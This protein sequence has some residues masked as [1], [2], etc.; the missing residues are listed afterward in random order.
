[1]RWW[2]L[3]A[4]LRV[5]REL[6]AEEP[7]TERLFWSELGQV[8]TRHYLVALDG[9]AGDDGVVGYAGLCSYPD[10]AFVQTVGVAVARQG[11][12]HGRRL[13]EA[14][15]AEAD[16]RG[17]RVVGLEVRADNSRARELYAALGF[18]DV[19]VRR[20]YYQPSGTDAVVMQRRQ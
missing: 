13:V 12:G 9:A 3:P 8:D 17:Q 7:W 18:T 11:E 5:E 6:F 15:L 10:E 19:G 2:H 4:V 1:M 16:R 20:G 14:L